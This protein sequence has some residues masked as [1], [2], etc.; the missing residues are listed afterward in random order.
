[1]RAVGRAE[2]VLDEALEKLDE[3]M[4]DAVLDRVDDSIRVLSGLCRSQ[5]GASWHTITRLDD[6]EAVLGYV[7]REPRLCPAG[8]LLAL[9]VAIGAVDHAKASLEWEGGVLDA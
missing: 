3:G 4:D 8:A 9:R 2:H 1:M 6:A 7:R 5:P